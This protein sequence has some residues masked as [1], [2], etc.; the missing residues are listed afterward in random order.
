MELLPQQE[1][2]R[3]KIL[4][5]LEMEEIQLLHQLFDNLILRSKSLAGID[6]DVFVKYCPIPGLWGHRIYR[7]IKNYNKSEDDFIN[8]QDFLC[9]LRYLCRSDDDELDRKIFEMFD[10]C[11]NKVITKV[12]M[13]QMLINF[14]DMGFSSSQNINVPDKFYLNIKESVVQCISKRQKDQQIQFQKEI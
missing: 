4:E 6:R 2:E 5:S 3:K 12:D 1:D 13:I 14:P 11:E 9:G 7:Y 8:F 10:L